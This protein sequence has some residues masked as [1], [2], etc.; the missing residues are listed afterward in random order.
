M[1]EISFLKTHCGG[2]LSVKKYLRDTEERFVSPHVFSPCLL[3]AVVSVFVGRQN[4]LV[5]SNGT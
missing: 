2:Q 4:V 1:K 5:G 3:G